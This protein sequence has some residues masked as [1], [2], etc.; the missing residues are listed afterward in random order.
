MAELYKYREGS[1]DE[2]R[3]EEDRPAKSHRRS[4]IGEFAKAGLAIILFFYVTISA[5]F[6]FGNPEVRHTAWDVLTRP[7]P[8]DII[9]ARVDRL[10]ERVDAIEHQ[11]P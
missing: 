4:I 8:I 6:L 2:E 7:G 5:M 3:A 9:K 1:S 10:T 11:S